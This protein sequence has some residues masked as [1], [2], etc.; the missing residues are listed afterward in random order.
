VAIS[1]FR[2]KGEIA[3]PFGFAMTVIL[4]V[5]ASVSCIY[6]LGSPDEYLKQCVRIEKGKVIPRQELLAGLVN[7]HYERND[8]EFIRGKF[9]VRGD[10]VEVYPAYLETALRIEFFG[11]EI[12]RI[13]EINPL[14]GQTINEKDRA[15][16]YP[17]KHFVITRPE[18]EIAIKN[19][20]AEL[21]ERLNVLKASDKL[22]EAQRLKQRTNYDMEMLRETGFCHGVE[23][24]SRVLSGR[25]PGSRPACLIDYFYSSPESAGDFLT[26]IDESHI[27]L[28]QVRGMYEGDRSRKQTLVDFGFRLP[29]ALDNRPLKFPEFEKL[30]G[31]TIFASATP[32]PIRTRKDQGRDSRPRNSSNGPYRPRSRYPPDR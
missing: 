25:A 2:R 5:V 32:G 23:N 30:V 24:Y 27:S 29:S 28:P 10:T 9:R 31:Q 13:R 21:E 11:D 14:T 6:N 4:I 20:E 26:I 19:I 3:S 16:V 12:E 7:I 18:L 22:L 15:Y 8:V 17:A 1:L